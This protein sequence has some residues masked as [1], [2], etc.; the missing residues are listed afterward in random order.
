MIIYASPSMF[1]ATI[2]SRFMISF[3]KNYPSHFHSTPTLIFVLQ[4][5]LSVLLEQFLSSQLL[6][7]LH[8]LLLH[9]RF[10]LGLPS[11]ERFRGHWSAYSSKTGEKPTPVLRMLDRV[12]LG[13][14]GSLLFMIGHISHH[15]LGLSVCKLLCLLLS[16][17]HLVVHRT[18]L[19]VILSQNRKPPAWGRFCPAANP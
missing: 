1:R 5:R 11:S 17:N 12:L 4:N 19:Q 14:R 8:L 2:L 10:E 13:D 9:L 6:D 18:L 3:I 16:P 7:G 15:L